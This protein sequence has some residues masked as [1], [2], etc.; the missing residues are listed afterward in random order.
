MSLVINTNAM[1]T[2][3]AMNLDRNQS[4]LQRSLAR[5]SSGSKVVT[6]ADDAGGL[7]VATKLKAVMN[8]NLRANQNVMNGISFLQVQDGA[9]KT[10]A[11]IL[12]RMSEL[13]TMS[14]DVTK[15]SDDIANYD[16]EFTQL[17]QQLSNIKDERFNGIELFTATQ[18][19]LSVFTTEKGMGDYTAATPA[20]AQVD[21][22]KGFTGDAATAQSDTISGLNGDSTA[23]VDTITGIAG[24]STDNYEVTIDGTTVVVGWNTNKSTT[25]DDMVTAINT[26]ATVNQIVTAAKDG[27]N[28][29]TLT[30]KDGVASFTSSVTANDN[31]GL[32]TAGN[33]GKHK[34]TITAGDLTAAGGSQYEVVV[35]DG[36]TTDTI[37]VAEAVEL[38]TGDTSAD[39]AAALAT[40][41]NANKTLAY[42]AVNNGDGTITIND[43]AA[44]T[45]F[46]VTASTTDTGAA[47]ILATTAAKAS[48]STT[49]TGALDS[50]SV[51]VGATTVSANWTTDAATTAA[52]I[53]DA[54][55]SNATIS[56]T[57]TATV[58]G[59]DVTLTANSTDTTFTASFATT[60]GGGGGIA[61][62]GAINTTPNGGDTFDISVDGTTVTVGMG[63]SAAATATSVAAALNSDA[64]VGSLVTAAVSGASSDEVTLTAQTAGT[65]FSTTVTANDGTGGATPAA[66]TLENTTSNASSTD[67]TYSAPNVSISRHELYQSGTSGLTASDGDELLDT[68]KTLSDF[69]VDDLKTFIQNAARSRAQNGA[70]MQRLE[71]SSDM[72]NT[73]YA[74][75]EQAHSRMVDVD[76][77]LETTHFARHNIMVQSAASMLAQANSISS[78][79]LQLLG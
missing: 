46:T 76:F 41:I 16:A 60:D 34:L 37:S 21:T 56:S 68:A 38:T 63:A 75:I 53:R 36:A 49:T 74:N 64:T 14:L 33:I 45:D 54:L 20:V 6:P 66:I 55:N 42:T 27:S 19:S 39:I 78:V 43:D 50:F 15:N 77:S 17:Q 12:D 73:N 47:A 4:N 30:A 7:A 51:T 29:V 1:A 70:E 5:L 44:G 71:W 28:N 10:A 40:K 58:T 62:A 13:K 8:R 52:A 25:A 2:T 67:A 61:A 69:S 22:L 11:N 31:D 59:N 3:A 18:N 35:T 32:T 26:D 48:S 9:L 79:A 65:A 57:L 72:L 24:D 23:Q